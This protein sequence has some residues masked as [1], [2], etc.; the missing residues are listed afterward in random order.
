L[1]ADFAAKLGL[2]SVKSVKPLRHYEAAAALGL[3]FMWAAILVFW[4]SM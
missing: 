1:S 4:P 2:Q 3:A